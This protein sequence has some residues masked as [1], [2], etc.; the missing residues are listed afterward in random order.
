MINENADKFWERVK[1]LIKEN[2]TTQEYVAGKCGVSLGVFKNW[3]YT[4]HLPDAAQSVYI[5]K[6][7]GTSVEFLVSGTEKKQ[8][9]SKAISLILS[10]V[11]LLR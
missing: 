4:K 3:I 8:D 5:A 6:A 1:T 7:L 11:D 2:R 10:A 9:N